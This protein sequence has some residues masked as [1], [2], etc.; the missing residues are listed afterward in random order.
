[1][2]VANAGQMSSLANS[3]WEPHSAMLG[4]QWYNHNSAW[5]VPLLERNHFLS[6]CVTQARLA[7]AVASRTL[8]RWEHGRPWCVEAASFVNAIENCRCQSYWLK[9]VMDVKTPLTTGDEKSAIINSWLLTC[10]YELNLFLELFI[11]E[12]AMEKHAA[13]SSVAA[14]TDLI[15]TLL[16][17]SEIE[18]CNN[19]HKL[20]QSG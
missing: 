3:Y 9:M 17:W 14:A 20:S 2:F 7:C 16:W 4:H 10:N 15:E 11:H 12:L 5:T 6:I 13:W 18:I 19:C 1:M 8:L